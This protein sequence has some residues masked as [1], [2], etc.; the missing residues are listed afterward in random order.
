MN[1]ESWGDAVRI[2]GSTKIPVK[3]VA[4]INNDMESMERYGVFVTDAENVTISANRVSSVGRVGIYATSNCN[5]ITILRNRVQEC[6]GYGIFM[7]NSKGGFICGN[8]V[9]EAGLTDSEQ[10]HGI[11]AYKCSGTG[12]ENAL[13][14]QKNVVE[15]NGREGAQ[16][17]KTSTS[18]Y[19][20]ITGN[21]VRKTKDRGIFVY[22]CEFPVVEKN[23]ETKAGE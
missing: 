14:I 2:M 1:G 12:P 16:G 19:V 23:R 18:D 11:Y 5:D 8:T 20:S 21:V 13:Y 15:G 4:V 22:S 10:I 7:A 17:I 3:G 9:K 6:G